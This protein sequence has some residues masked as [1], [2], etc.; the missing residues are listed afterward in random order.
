MKEAT[1]DSKVERQL[2]LNSIDW[3]IAIRLWTIFVLRARLYMTVALLAVLATGPGALAETSSSA[4]S[5]YQFQQELAESLANLR[6]DDARLDSAIVAVYS[7]FS[8][9][10][11]RKEALKRS[12]RTML[13]QDALPALVAR[14]LGP[15]LTSSSSA[16]QRLARA[17]QILVELRVKGLRRIPPARQAEFVRFIQGVTGSL[18]PLACRQMFDGTL[19]AVASSHAEHAYMLAMPLNRFHS[20]VTLYEEAMVAELNGRP[21]VHLLTASQRKQM[22]Q[23]YDAAIE[24]RMRK[25]PPEVVAGI[26][27]GLTQAPAEVACRFHREALAAGLDLGA[28]Y[29][30]WYVASFVDSLQNP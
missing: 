2:R 16:S 20:L 28:P 9:E 29:R 13:G 30:N 6:N 1:L 21:A 18:P 23:A 26:A 15:R 8:V 10:P 24:A 19:D 11:V 12:L 5:T 7:G 27:S 4:L 22:D 25:M 14:S 3:E 17:S